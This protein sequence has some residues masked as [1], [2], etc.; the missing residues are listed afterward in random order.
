MWI[1]RWPLPL[2]TGGHI[3]DEA[4]SAPLYT[5]YTVKWRKCQSSSLANTLQAK[6][7][8][9]GIERTKDCYQQDDMEADWD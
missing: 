2:G 8:L 6:S 1:L 5:L 9:M 4:P 7:I 3:A